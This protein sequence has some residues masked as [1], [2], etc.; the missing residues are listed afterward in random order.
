MANRLNN[1]V[2]DL[3]TEGEINLNMANARLRL[4]VRANDIGNIDIAFR[5]YL[6]RVR[7]KHKFR[8]NSAEIVFWERLGRAAAWKKEWAIS[9]MATKRAL[10]L[11]DANESLGR[12][13]Q[14]L[15]NLALAYSQAG[16]A[17]L[18]QQAFEAFQ[19][20]IVRKDTSSCEGLA[21][22]NAAIEIIKLARQSGHQD[23]R[24]AI[25]VLEESR[26]ALDD[27]RFCQVKVPTFING[28]LNSSR[29][30]YGFDTDAE[31]G[32]NLAWTQSAFELLGDV[33][34]VELV[35]KTRRDVIAQQLDSPQVMTVS[36][37]QEQ[38]AL[39]GLAFRRACRLKGVE[40]CLQ[41]GR[42]LLELLNKGAVAKDFAV[43]SGVDRSLL[44]TRSTL[45]ALLAEELSG[46]SKISSSEEKAFRDK[47]G[48]ITRPTYAKLESLLQFFSRTTPQTTEASERKRMMLQYLK[49]EYGG[50]Q[51]S[52]DETTDSQE[53]SIF[54]LERALTVFARLNYSRALLGLYDAKKP[55]SSLSVEQIS[56]FDFSSV[57]DEL[58]AANDYF[59]RAYKWSSLGVSQLALNLKERVRLALESESLELVDTSTTEADINERKMFKV[60]QRLDNPA[61][62]IKSLAS[63]DNEGLDQVFAGRL[64]RNIH[65]PWHKIHEKLF[66]S[67]LQPSWSS[68]T[69]DDLLDLIRS[70]DRSLGLKATLGRGLARNKSMR[71][72]VNAQLKEI[73]QAE[74]ELKGWYENVDD[75]IPDK[76]FLEQ[77]TDRNQA[78]REAISNI[79]D[80]GLAVRN[81]AYVFEPMEI[82]KSL[83]K[84]EIMIVPFPLG[85]KLA[86]LTIA[87][88]STVSTQAFRVTVTEVPFR[89]ANESVKEITSLLSSGEL[90]ER[91]HI[92]DWLLNVAIKNASSS[93]TIVLCGSFLGAPVPRIPHPTLDQFALVHSASPTIFALGRQSEDVSA[94]GLVRFSR[95]VEV[96]E[97]KT[98]MTLPT[99][100]L[101]DLSNDDEGAEAFDGR[102]D[103]KVVVVFEDRVEIKARD[104]ENTV[105]YQSRDLELINKFGLA[106]DIANITLAEGKTYLSEVMAPSH[107]WVFQDVKV[108]REAGAL[109]LE[110]E[111]ALM[112][113][114]GVVIVPSLI[115]EGVRSRLI[116]NFISGI[117][118]HGAA[119]SLKQ[120]IFAERDEYPAVGLIH[121]IGSPAQ[122][123]RAR[124][125]SAKKKIRRVERL[126]VKAIRK[127]RIS[128][129]I[130][131]L[132]S[133]RRLQKVSRSNGRLKRT[134]TYE[135]LVQYLRSAQAL[136][137]AGII[138][139]EYIT[140]L[141]NSNRKGDAARQSV[142]RAEILSQTGKNS[143]AEAA[144]LGAIEQ[145][146]ERSDE[147]GLAQAHSSL[148]MH[149]R[150]SLA[151]KK[152]AGAFER[153]AR[154]HSKQSLI[155]SS[156]KRQVKLALDNFKRLG[157]VYTNQLADSKG[158]KSVYE[159]W[160][161]QVSTASE[162][163]E[164]L[165]GLAR[166]ARREGDFET[167]LAIADKTQRLAQETGDKVRELEAVVEGANV[168]WY[169]G[170]YVIGQKLC[171][172]SLSIADQNIST[173]RKKKNPQMGRHIKG[174][175]Y[176]LSVCGLLNMSTNNFLGARRDLVQAAD[177][178]RS[179]GLQT[180]LAT[181]YN[182]LG[183]AY[184]E[185]GLAKEAIKTF[186]KALVIDQRLADK[187]GLA[188]D[189]RNLGAGL[190]KIN[191]RNAEKTL[192][193]ALS[194]AREV[195]DRNNEMRTLFE[196]G[197]LYF[198][199]KNYPSARS[200]LQS[201][202]K[203]ADERRAQDLR[204]KIHRLLGLIDY[205][206]GNRI[207]AEEE[208]LLA[209]EIVRSMAL[210]SG[211]SEFGVSPY[212][213]F[214]DIM[215]LLVEED[216]LEEAYQFLEEGRVLSQ[217]DL[218]ADARIQFQNQEL[219]S[220]LRKIRA[221][222]SSSVARSGRDKIKRIAPR[223]SMLLK[224]GN[225]DRIADTLKAGQTIV[226]YRLTYRGLLIFVLD[227]E[228]VQ[229]EFVPM[230]G[231]YARALIRDFGRKMLD[232]AEVSEFI[233]ELSNLLIKPIEKY[234]QVK[235]QV[236][237]VVSGL[238]RYVSFAALN[239]GKEKI[240]DKFL[241]FQTLA[242]A[243]AFSQDMFE[244][245][246]SGDMEVLTFE[247]PETEEKLP[248]ASKEKSLI[249]EALLGSR[250]RVSSS[251]N[252]EEF[253]NSL[254]KNRAVVHYA[255]HFELNERDSLASVIRFETDEMSLYE[256]FSFPMNA[257]L[258]AFSACQSRVGAKSLSPSDK[259]TGREMF[260]MT[261]SILMGGAKSVLSSI[262]RVD[263]VA[264][265]VLMKRFYREL[266]EHSPAV[267]LRRASQIVRKYHPHPSWWANFV[268]VNGLNTQEQLA[269][270]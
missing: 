31:L 27:G 73:Y 50:T 41:Q 248:F 24:Q 190:G 264:S 2:G 72:Q 246:L 106:R 241:S 196:L 65:I 255:G 34:A 122:N 154:I 144:Y 94:S 63:K 156:D 257:A 139:D 71:P 95:N 67:T 212:T 171:A 143:E 123:K 151:F 169:Q 52:L 223:L 232:V 15:G 147:I 153:A 30:P 205:Q 78:Y 108:S 6:E 164:P 249:S 5:L 270:K 130:R 140:F 10:V 16:E 269:A 89:L 14:L 258:V 107:V 226:S 79:S 88:S 209:V 254:G 152:A 64:V 166:V 43:D 250:F 167:A 163:I 183:R 93:N 59:R 53:I 194:L 101:R 133:L 124:I 137:R 136:S 92:W 112:N 161:S 218:L 91:E 168:A 77:L 60:L 211:S 49:D 213:V 192:V 230:E 86:V 23:V 17:E 26:T 18:S 182:N 231:A 104:L 1:D 76:Y 204:W 191:D 150:R 186:R 116:S 46:T 19:S 243:T 102:D 22:R 224:K 83:H 75:R 242:P 145:L 35:Q 87:G 103:P 197:R 252:K 262:S 37:I 155:R 111:T 176:S 105:M 219:S 13:P 215:I 179:A 216:R 110:L 159:R 268:F 193:N 84:N 39:E 245:T 188:Y 126:A 81:K 222:K 237:F 256:L 74:S 29:A 121:F 235:E 229:S 36:L 125:R 240:I 228:G 40:E 51:E 189:L 99:K 244:E 158:A 56:Q 42:K 134:R 9:I 11:A 260:S 238:L 20:E 131:H 3:K 184:L 162:R 69:S 44:Y 225:P 62:T 128:D 97:K 221:T 195:Q 129:V 48:A 227:A 208:L 58:V 114:P 206:D 266:R 178:A 119:D 142:V 261:E 38:L 177:L 233:N 115:D 165:L 132:E 118:K 109:G 33:E 68:S 25:R 12:K 90:P 21:L 138:Q 4:G 32:L 236:A 199:K 265:A 61:L 214:D 82:F 180:E 80:I 85:E 47:I 141:K 7:A 120:A 160:L 174:K 267:A 202:L 100:R 66:S 185:F 253:V 117:D 203:L 173:E 55:T 201:A 234:F 45:I 259:P 57:D 239:F 8:S 263:D 210:R 198:R 247:G 220:T 200:S 157:S 146:E 54:E 148:G 127:Q 170:D 217:F 187:F 207:G 113:V 70:I 181:Q 251:T 149:Y 135:F 98:S 172:K 175:I 96:D 28:P